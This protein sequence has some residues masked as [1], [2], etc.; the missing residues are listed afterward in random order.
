MAARAAEEA[1]LLGERRAALAELDLAMSL[2][3]R[4]LP[5]MPDD[6]SPPWARFFYRSV[7]AAMAASIH[8]RLGNAQQARDAAAWALRTL[9]PEKVKTRGFILAEVARAAARM[10]E[11]EL[12]LESAYSAAEVAKR[13]EHVM[14]QRKLRSLV[15]L[16]APHMTSEPVRELVKRLTLNYLDADRAHDPA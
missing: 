16:L 7:L 12:A 11:V 1:A 2:G 9:S 3:S 13:S 6:T 8:G 15:G 14:T 5:P 4:L 10:G